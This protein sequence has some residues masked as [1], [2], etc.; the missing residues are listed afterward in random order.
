MTGKVTSSKV[1]GAKVEIVYDFDVQGTKLQTST[2][3]TLT[4]K[5]LSGTKT[6]DL[7]LALAGN[8]ASRSVLTL[9]QNMGRVAALEVA[10]TV[11][12]S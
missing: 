8:K 6:R 3:G 5:T 4:G 12:Q 1:D 10:G 7:I 2:Q 11:R 9:A